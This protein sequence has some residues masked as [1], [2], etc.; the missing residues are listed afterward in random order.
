MELWLQFFPLVRAR[1]G[2]RLQEGVETGPKSSDYNSMLTP[3]QKF[4]SV[5]RSFTMLARF[6]RALT[7]E[8]LALVLF[9]SAPSA[10]AANVFP[11]LS[12]VPGNSIGQIVDIA[13]SEIIF[14]HDRRA[15]RNRHERRADRHRHDRGADRNRHDRRAGR[16]WDRPHYKRGYR[17]SRKHRDGYRRDNDGWWFPLAAFALGAIILNQQNQG[18]TSRPTYSSWDH[19]PAGNLSAHDR[20][21][22]QRY[23]SYSRTNKTFQPYNGPRKYC[24][25]PYDLL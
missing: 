3:A 8:A 23:R 10:N 21:C 17:G 12:P 5:E 2:H 16:D 18:L 1:D 6:Q 22:D 15:D 4:D 11:S 9:I 14:I 24:N 20:W 19:I 13:D 7:A 25:S